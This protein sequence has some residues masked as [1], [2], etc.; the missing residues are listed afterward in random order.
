[1]PLP[2]NGED[3]HRQQG[4]CSEK[5]V[6]ARLEGSV[7]GQVKGPWTKRHRREDHNRRGSRTMRCVRVLARIFLGG[8]RYDLM[9]K[10]Q[11]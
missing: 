11:W 1:M 9:Y 7:N 6:Y 4:E 3:L 8:V 5:R 10:R 2:N